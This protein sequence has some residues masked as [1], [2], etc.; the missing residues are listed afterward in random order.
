MNKLWLIIQREYLTRVKKRSFILSTLLT[1]LAFGVL[2]IVIGVIFS[3]ESDETRTIAIVDQGNILERKISDSKNLYFQF[4]S[5]SLD[6]LKKAVENKT[7]DGVLLIPEVKDL[8]SKDLTIYYYSKSPPTLDVQSFIERRV[9]KSLRDYKIGQL[10]MEP[11]QIEALNTKV[12]IDPEPL[13]DTD[14]NVS[15]ISTVIGVA[16]GNIMGIIMYIVVF[17]YGM[18]VMRS[19]ME[20]KTSRIVEVMISSVKPFQLMLGKI[21]G[22][23]AVGLTQ[24]IIWAIMIPL[25]SVGVNLIF[26]FDMNN[27]AEMPQQSQIDPEDLQGMITLVIQELGSQNWWLILPTFVLYFLGGYFLYASMFAAIGSAIGDDMGEGQSLTLPI[28]IPI[29]IALYIMLV[30]VRAPHSTLAIWSSIFPLFSP[31]VMPARLAFD[32]PLWQLA[33]SLCVLIA[34][35]IF[36]IWLAGRIYRVGILMYGKKSSVKEIFKWML[37]KT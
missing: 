30:T 15:Q 19:V 27:M 12:T 9:E 13:K 17:V 18:M 6:N 29:V 7:Y 37:A 34:T 36:C 14:E 33:L 20:E 16:L 8:Y 3:Y 11:K 31:I 21:V 22:V 4:P 24:F 32:P 28:S 26:N 35:V 25:I 1:P 2:F 10:S 5:S 23:G